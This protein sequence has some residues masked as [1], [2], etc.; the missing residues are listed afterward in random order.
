MIKWEYIGDGTYRLKVPRGW[1]IRYDYE[2]VA[3]AF[4]ED[5]NHEWTL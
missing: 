2:G 1:F 4:Y 3:M 5:P